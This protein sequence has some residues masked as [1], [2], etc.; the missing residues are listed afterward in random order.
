MNE[1]LRIF[2]ESLASLEEENKLLEC[3]R[4][5]LVPVLDQVL[6][7]LTEENRV[8]LLDA[9]EVDQIYHRR[10]DI[11]RIVVANDMLDDLFEVL[12]LGIEGYSLE[13]TYVCL[14]RQFDAFLSEEVACQKVV[15]VLRL[16][17]LLGRDWGAEDLEEHQLDVGNDIIDF[18]S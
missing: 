5:N 15:L 11:G 4:F 17:S 14:L 1:S 13:E 12:L 6:H 7:G 16:A 9:D 8:F 3:R 10:V 18:I 2:L